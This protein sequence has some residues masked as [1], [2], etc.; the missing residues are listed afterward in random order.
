MIKGII[1]L[2]SPADESFFAQLD[3]YEIGGGDR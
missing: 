1:M 3:K 2:S